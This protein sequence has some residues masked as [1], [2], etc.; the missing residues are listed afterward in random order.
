MMSMQLLVDVIVCDFLMRTT[1]VRAV[2][3]GW[4]QSMRIEQVLRV[5]Q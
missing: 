4:L 3:P 2:G 5:W 1:P